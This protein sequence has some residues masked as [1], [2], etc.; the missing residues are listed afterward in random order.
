MLSTDRCRLL[1]DCGLGSQMACRQTLAGHFGAGLSLDAV[2][3]THAHG[4]HIN[5]SSLRVIEQMGIPL[6]IHEK[7]L[8][9]LIETHYRGRNFENLR[10]EPFGSD[11]FQIGDLVIQPVEIPH[12]PSHYT[13]GFVVSFHEKL[14]WYKLV[15]ATDFNDSRP[16]LEH[17]IDADFIYIESNHDLKLLA[18][19][20]NYASCFH[21]PNPK[22]AE[23]LFNARLRSSR[24]P[25]TVMLGHLS[26]QRNVPQLAIK[27]VHSA[28]NAGDLPLDFELF[29][30]PRFEPSHTISIG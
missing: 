21:M 9:K 19:N 17:C 24:A 3:V 14:R 2:I 13:C 5:Y 6:H 20:P 15:L 7:C 1:I 28:F 11:H 10:I 22:T 26:E 23:L 29:A 8:P 12:A 27:T 4:D 16:L 25:S 30:A 18:Q